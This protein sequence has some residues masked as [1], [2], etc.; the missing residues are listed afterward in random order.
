MRHPRTHAWETTAGIAAGGA[1]L[2]ILRTAGGRPLRSAPT[3]TA[4]GAGMAASGLILYEW[5][6]PRSWLYG[7]VF[8]HARTQERVVAL[9]FDDGPCHPYTE[10]LLEILDQ[11]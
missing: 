11:E 2:S 8:S 5:F 4:A 9:T 10:Q 1:V 3:L 6:T 7:P